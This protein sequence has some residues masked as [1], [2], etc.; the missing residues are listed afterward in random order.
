M[1]T[2][3]F[4]GGSVVKTLSFHCRGIGLISSWGTKIPP[5]VP[6]IKKK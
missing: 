5:A 2:R 3:D 4:P 6:Q 1:I